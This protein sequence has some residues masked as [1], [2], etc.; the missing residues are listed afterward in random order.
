M[1]NLK[2]LFRKIFGGRQSTFHSDFIFF[3]ELNDVISSSLSWRRC[4]VFLDIDLLRIH[5]VLA[6]SPGDVDSSPYSKLVA[7]LSANPDLTY[8]NSSLVDFFNSNQPLNL[9][10]YFDIEATFSGNSILECLPPYVMP[11]PW[12]P[13]DDSFDQSPSCISR[14]IANSQSSIISELSSNGFQ[15][16]IFHGWPGIGPVSLELGEFEFM[17]LKSIFRSISESGYA[18]SSNGIRGQILFDPSS[19]KMSVKVLSGGHRACVLGGLGFRK[20]PVIFDKN[21]SWFA[22]CSDVL[23]WDSVNKNILSPTQ[24]ITIT[25]RFIDGIHP[26]WFKP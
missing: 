2:F 26:S 13:L 14:Y 18:L 10:K 4:I 7:E 12:M 6:C 1:R 19:N 3:E 24:A 16:K 8:Q 22:S 20:I 15:S 25:R 9:L 11:F 21:D 5:E 23:N 17:R